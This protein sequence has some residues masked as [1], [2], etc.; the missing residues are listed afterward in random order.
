AALMALHD[1]DVKRTMACGIAGL[2]VAADSLSA[3]K[4]A[5][6]K[7]IRDEDGLAIDFEIEGD[8]PK[9]GNNDPRVDD[10]A[11]ELVSVFMGKIRKLKTYR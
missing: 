4:Y 11:C 10:I 6:V 8:Y 3:I 2:S 1:R 5:T 9:F 7:P